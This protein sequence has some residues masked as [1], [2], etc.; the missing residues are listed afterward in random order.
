MLI[1]DD[2]SRTA[3]VP[4]FRPRRSNTNRSVHLEYSHPEAALQAPSQNHTTLSLIRFSGLG[5]KI[6]EHGESA[7]DAPSV[8]KPGETVKVTN[9]I[10]TFL[11][12]SG[13]L[14]IAE[15][16]T[17]FTIKSLTSQAQSE[18]RRNELHFMSGNVWISAPTRNDESTALTITGPTYSVHLDDSS[19]SMQTTPKRLIMTLDTGRVSMK[20]K[21]APPIFLSGGQSLLVNPEG[22]AIHRRLDSPTFVSPSPHDPR[23]MLK[24]SPS[25][26]QLAIGWKSLQG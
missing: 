25:Q 11:M 17:Q 19:A 22:V 4:I 8:L 10:G 26:M 2:Y 23:S 12:P 13:R 20:L 21:D 6:T 7:L 24:W 9:G 15:G 16:N 1:P 14:L 18:T 5:T 3:L